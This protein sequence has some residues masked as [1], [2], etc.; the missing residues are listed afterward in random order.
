MAH[1]NDFLLNAVACDELKQ[2]TLWSQHLVLHTRDSLRKTLEYFGF[3]NVLIEGV[4][5]HSLSNHLAWLATGKPWGHKSPLSLLDCDVLSDAYRNTLC[6]I[7]ATD[8]LVAIA[9]VP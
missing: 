5:R 3:E 7:D 4:Q 9:K 6:R 8:T 1:A 2:C